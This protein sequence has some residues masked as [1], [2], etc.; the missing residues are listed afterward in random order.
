MTPTNLIAFVVELEKIGKVVPYQQETKRTCS[1]ACLHAV[2]K[3]YGV[4]ADEKL[5]SKLIGVHKAG[6]ELYQVVGV[7]RALGFEAKQHEF[8]TLADATQVVLKGVP[9][10]CDVQSWTKPG[11]GHYVVFAGVK[12][13]NAEIMDPNTPGNWR[14]MPLKEFDDR[15][16]DGDNV[17]P[18]K[19]LV[20]AAVIIKRK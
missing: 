13:G 20:R 16:W 8:D 4:Q 15:W 1:A 11:S 18:D 5:L 14:S 7:A 12:N 10:I 6:A 9:L 3:H 2:L 19:T 17:Y